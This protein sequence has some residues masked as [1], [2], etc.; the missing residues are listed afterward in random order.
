MRRTHFTNVVREKNNPFQK[1]FGP[2]VDPWHT[3][4]FISLKVESRANT[5]T[6]FHLILPLILLDVDENK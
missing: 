5:F 1:E 2:F 6:S 3:G 4:S